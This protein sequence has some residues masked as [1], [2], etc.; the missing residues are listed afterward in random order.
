MSMI[1]RYK[2]I[3]TGINESLVSLW[4][5][6][7]GWR[8]EAYHLLVF[9]T[10]DVPHLAL[11]GKLGGLVHP[12]DGQCHLND[13]SEYSASTKMVKLLHHKTLSFHFK[14][15][16]CTYC[17]LLLSPYDVTNFFF[18]FMALNWINCNSP[19]YVKVQEQMRC[20]F[21]S[22]GPI[23]SSW[24]FWEWE[25]SLRQKENKQKQCVPSTAN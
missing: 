4:Q 16:L 3:Q 21:S 2:K 23:Q 12:H 11:D 7:I 19:I 17:F 20:S 8:K 22:L 18:F 24:M 15:H 25:R 13:K 6:R 9:A 1:L 14:W 5:E 10:D